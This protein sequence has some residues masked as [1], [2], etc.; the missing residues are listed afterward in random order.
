MSKFVLTVDT[1]F[2]DA[3]AYTGDSFEESGSLIYT[4]NCKICKREV[5][6]Y[7]RGNHLWFHKYKAGLYV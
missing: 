6:S 3:F 4:Y 2:A 5:V 1:T 7:S